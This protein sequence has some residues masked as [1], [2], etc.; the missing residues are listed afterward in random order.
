DRIRRL[1]ILSDGPA[2]SIV[3]GVAGKR[4]LTSV[5]VTNSIPCVIEV[6]DK[7]PGC[8]PP[9]PSTTNGDEDLD[10][11]DTSVIFEELKM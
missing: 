3:I 4:D 5:G 7:R 10:P 9:G 8:Q 11:E 1:A 6:E 2:V